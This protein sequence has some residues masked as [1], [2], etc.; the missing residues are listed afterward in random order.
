[1]PCA[2]SELTEEEE[3][4]GQAMAD[5]TAC[6]MKK[7]DQKNMRRVKHVDREG[8]K[9]RALKEQSK[10]VMSDRKDV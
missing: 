4:E 1:M 5:I 7:N 10:V 9:P 2:S 3:E 8:T 6:V